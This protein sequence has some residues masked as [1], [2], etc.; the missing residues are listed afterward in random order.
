MPKSQ[1]DTLVLS[2]RQ[3]VSFT[4]G[5]ALA[6]GI[7][8]THSQAAETDAVI[9]LRATW[10]GK[11]ILKGVRKHCESGE[12][13]RCEFQVNR[14]LFG[15]TVRR[16]DSFSM[17]W[18]CTSNPARS[19]THSIR[20]AEYGT[21]ISASCPIPEPLKPGEHA[22]NADYPYSFRNVILS[23]KHDTEI[24]PDLGQACL[25]SVRKVLADG[26]ALKSHF[27]EPLIVPMTEKVP[28]GKLYHHTMNESVRTS[29]KEL[30]TLQP[31][32][33][34]LFK[35]VRTREMKEGWKRSED[36]FGE[37]PGSQN[38]RRFGWR[39]FYTASTTTGSENYGPVMITLSISPEAKILKYDP[40]AWQAAVADL[41]EQFPTIKANCDLRFGV[42]HDALGDVTFQ[43]FVTVMAEEMGVDVVDYN[44]RS[45]WYMLLAP[46]SV[47]ALEVSFQ[48]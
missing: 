24:E 23:G 14:S 41:G 36:Y 15:R 47:T 5:L 37:G 30:G 3:L 4:T 31:Q 44:Q 10:S 11:S 25:K 34:Y 1:R 26:G 45:T 33:E 12:K 18:S 6:L 35:F 17:E 42:A 21:H 16:S 13:N 32:L 40:A 46:V 9:I 22:K 27:L 39:N 48:Y 28:G 20:Q 19:Q 8:A 7:I 38:F 43:N 29:L 2:F